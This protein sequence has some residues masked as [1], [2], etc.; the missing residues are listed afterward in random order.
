VQRLPALQDALEERARSVNTDPAYLVD[1]MKD[2]R[3]R[4]ARVPAAPLK[5]VTADASAD[6]L[7]A[8]TM[9]LPRSQDGGPTSAMPH[10]VRGRWVEFIDDNGRRSRARLNWISPVGGVCL[11]KDYLDNA[12]FTIALADLNRQL[13]DGRARIVESLGISR[14]AIEY[15][16][17]HLGLADA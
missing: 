13:D 14:H 17:R 12:T 4:L 6:P 8:T 16:I 5:A 2:L 1:F 7:L 15:A 11:F 9:W 10:L 3:E